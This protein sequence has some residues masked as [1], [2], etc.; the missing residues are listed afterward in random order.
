M[1]DENEQVD[2]S[3]DDEGWLKLLIWTIFLVSVLA[4]GFAI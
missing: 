2:N 3:F 1:L 4:L